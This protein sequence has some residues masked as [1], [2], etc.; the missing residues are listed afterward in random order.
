[1][2]AAGGGGASG[3]E[4][5]KTGGSGN[6]AGGTS[7]GT[8]AGIAGT[9]GGGGSASPYSETNCVETDECASYSHNECYNVYL[10]YHA[11]HNCARTVNW[12]TC[13]I[14]CVDRIDSSWINSNMAGG[15]EPGIGWNYEKSFI[16][17]CDW[18]EV[19]CDTVYG[20]PGNGGASSI[21]SGVTL[22]SK[23]DGVNSGNGHVTISFLS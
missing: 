7:V 10:T 11:S 14:Y 9:N 4:S 13:T 16:G 15:P 12:D 19:E 2:T 20:N 22:I 1:M 3:N 6:G 18:N 17:T 23:T 8:G 21:G 5:G